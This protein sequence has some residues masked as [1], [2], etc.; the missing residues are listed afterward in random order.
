MMTNGSRAFKAEDTGCRMV[1]VAGASFMCLGEQESGQES[2]EQE[3]GR[4]QVLRV[5]WNHGMNFRFFSE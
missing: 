1:P 2:G 5:L 4:G 3:S